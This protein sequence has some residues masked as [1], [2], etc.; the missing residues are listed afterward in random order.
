MEIFIQILYD[1]LTPANT[2]IFTN[3]Q[4]IEELENVMRNFVAQS[5][6]W[7]LDEPLNIITTQK[8]HYNITIYIQPTT[9]R[10][11]SDSVNKDLTCGIIA[12]VAEQITDLDITLCR[13]SSYLVGNPGASSL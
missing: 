3:L 12:S 8:H 2:R 7:Y 9:F 13:T 10:I 1:M 6:P 11:V 5:A 4:E